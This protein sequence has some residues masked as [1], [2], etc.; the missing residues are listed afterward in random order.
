M[1]FASIF[2]A[3]ALALGLMAGGA[4]AA[5]VVIN[6]DDVPF[7]TVVGSNYSGVTFSNAQVISIVLPGMSGTQGIWSVSDGYNP[8]P[9]N[10]ISAVF[11]SAASSVS[12]TGIDIGTDG[13]VMTAYDAA[14]GGN[15][16]DT[17]LVFGSS[18]GVGQF[19]TLTLTGSNIFRVEFSQSF[20]SGAGDGALFDTFV[21]D[22]AAAAVPEPGS[23]ALLGLGLVGLAA[24]RKRKQA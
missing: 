12:L 8:L 13:F 18:V 21:Y 15:I 9:A 3:T 6:F 16:V 23:L 14:V 2:R 17:D 19:F 1:K 10:P 4:H 11:G 24:A 22:T 7:G 20:D 5:P